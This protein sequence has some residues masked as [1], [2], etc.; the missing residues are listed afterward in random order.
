MQSIVKTGKTVD[1]AVNEAL[2]ELSASLDE[3][4]I[5]I[6]EEPKVGFLGIIGSK[7][8]VVRIS[9]Q[10]D[11][12]KTLLK[13]NKEKKSNVEETKKTENVEKHEEVTTKD[14]GKKD[15]DCDT[16]VI[17]ISDNK[18]TYLNKNK[19]ED[20]NKELAETSVEEKKLIEQA[21]QESDDE[22]SKDQERVILDPL[23]TPEEVQQFCEKWI[24][25]ILNEMSIEARV[26]IDMSKANNVSVN[27]V[28]ISSTDMGIII[29]RRAETID[30]LQY[31]LSVTL[32][33]HLEDYCRVF[34]NVG[35]YRE[36]RKLSIEKLAKRN[37]EKVIK[38]RRPI[39]LEPMNAYE[40]RIV[41]TYLQNVDEVVTI[42]EGREP[43]RKVVIRL[44]D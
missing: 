25:E 20:D 24:A 17:N 37:A 8:A 18:E 39:A 22:E 44:K 10:E 42:S 30:A 13:D 32:N 2:K 31:L 15:I 1:E 38:F 40:R 5:E 12:F 7:S 26:E 33:R 27:I 28:D 41:H 4:N 11:R 34:V 14:I 16:V 35:F 23:K 21:N 19:T 9:L 29:G 36:R 3:V 6:L 43:Y